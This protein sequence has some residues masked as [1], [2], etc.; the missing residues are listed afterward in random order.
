M[1]I[2]KIHF[3]KLFWTGGQDPWG[4]IWVRTECYYYS[5]VNRISLDSK[6]I[7]RIIEAFRDHPAGRTMG[8][9][10]REQSSC[11]LE[12]NF[13]EK[14]KIFFLKGNCWEVLHP[15]VQHFPFRHLVNSSAP[16][17]FP[18]SVLRCWFCLGDGGEVLGM[19]SSRTAGSGWHVG[20][21]LHW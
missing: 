20:R 17:P 3:D 18:L 2:W 7:G 14:S 6:G 9:G 11:H 1:W 13:G 21:H 15:C 8:E 16:C 5:W 19:V 4:T 10:K 12:K